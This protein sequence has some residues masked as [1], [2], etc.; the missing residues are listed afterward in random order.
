M[1]VETSPT[2]GTAAGGTESGG[3]EAI[4]GAA[5]GVAGTRGRGRP[6]VVDVDA[7]AEAAFALWS[8][9]GYTATGWKELADATGVSTR[10]LMRHFG[11]RDRIAWAEV[12]SANDRL[13]RSIAEM[14]PETPVSDAVR[15]AIVASVSHDAHVRRSA[16]AWFRLIAS[17][18]E[19]A[20]SAAAADR[21]WTGRLAEF[22]GSRLPGASA[23]TCRALAAALQAATFAA[24]TSWVE[25]GAEGDPADAV[26]QALAWIDFTRP[27]AGF[28]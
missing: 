28:V 16:A 5:G 6:S 27:T 18:P 12:E 13:V 11:T 21:A 3:I 7:V 22:L 9:R 1:A 24:L 14:S 26:D 23:E 20:A 19:L 17:E 10:T 2:G 8:E 15:R 4:S 25:A